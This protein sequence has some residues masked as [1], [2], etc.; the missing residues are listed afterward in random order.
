MADAAIGGKTG[1]D[2]LGYKNQVGSFADAAAVV[3]HA[4]FLET[5]PEAE[6]RSGYAE[7]LKH[8]LIHDATR[9]KEMAALGKLPQEWSEIVEAAVATKLHFTQADPHEKGIRKALNLGH[10]VGHAIESH[11]LQ[12]NPSAPML[13]GDAVAA[14]I[15]IESH[16]AESRHL[17]SKVEA[18]EVRG[19]LAAIFPKAPFFPFEITEIAAWCLQD[20]KNQGGKVNCSLLKGIGGFALDQFVELGE[21]E[22]ALQHYFENYP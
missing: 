19:L 9:W 18:E 13:H 21:I 22:A 7:V 15:W 1:I 2:F 17:I 11:F 5:L 14:G 4:P 8:A 6:L 12:Q 16:F 10:T 20:K 3:L